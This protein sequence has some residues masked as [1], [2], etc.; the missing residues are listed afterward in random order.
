MA[1]TTRLLAPVSWSFALKGSVKPELAG[2]DW[3]LRPA[4]DGGWFM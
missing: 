1:V 2:M 4:R 3:L